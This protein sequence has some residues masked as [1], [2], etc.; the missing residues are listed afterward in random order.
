MV[1]LVGRKSDWIAALT[2]WGV[3]GLASRA[4]AAH[5]DPRADPAPPRRPAQDALTED[6]L[7]LDEQAYRVQSDECGRGVQASCV[8]AARWLERDGDY[9]RAVDAYS[10]ACSSGVG[11]GCTYLGR[12]FVKNR[13]VPLNTARAAALYREGCVKLDGLGCLLSAHTYEQTS[14]PDDRR[15]AEQYTNACK[16]DVHEACAWLGAEGRRLLAGSC[17]RKHARACSILGS[18][19]DNGTAGPRD[20]KQAVRY[21]TLACDGGAA[22]ACNN[23]GTTLSAG[24]GIAKDAP[25]AIKLYEKACQAKSPTGCFNLAFE[26]SPGVRKGAHFFDGH[27]VRRTPSEPSASRCGSD[28]QPKGCSR[29]ANRLGERRVDSRAR[30]QLMW[31]PNQSY[32]WLDSTPLTLCARNPKRRSIPARKRC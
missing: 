15:V 27:A 9:E 26:Y 22:E 30:T 19:F 3:C 28:A 13:G 29:I 11:S 17:Q 12:L 2:A 6:A 8:Q 23:L 14:P 16:L 5:F 18:F 31:P 25:R 10:R 24:R 32:L 20:P 4:N 21:Y 7:R 1:V